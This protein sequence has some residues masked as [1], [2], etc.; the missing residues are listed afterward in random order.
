MAFIKENSN[1]RTAVRR[2]FRHARATPGSAMNVVQ[3]ITGQVLPF[4]ATVFTGFNL[5]PTIVMLF[6]MPLGLAWLKPRD[7]DAI[8]LDTEKHPDAPP[9]TNAFKERWWRIFDARIGPLPLPVYVL[10]LVVLG[11]M[12]L[13]WDFSR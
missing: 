8:V 12:T 5:V 4:S 6:A 7:E 3:K 1:P 2:P 11:A 10:L 9:R 13:G